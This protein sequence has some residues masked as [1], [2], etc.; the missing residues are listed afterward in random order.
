DYNVDFESDVRCCSPKHF[1]NLLDFYRPSQSQKYSS[2]KNRTI[3][4]RSRVSFHP[5]CTAR[6]VAPYGWLGVEEREITIL[7]LCSIPKIGNVVQ[8]YSEEAARYF[9]N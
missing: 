5:L 4:F 7:E 2:R 1:E 9:V 8:T 6:A 3:E